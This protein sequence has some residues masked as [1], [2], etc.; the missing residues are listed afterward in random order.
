MINKKI[1]L[2]IPNICFLELTE[3]FPRDLKNE[4]ESSMVNE[5]SVFQSLRFS[6]ILFCNI[7]YN[8]YIN[9]D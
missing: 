2:N 8:Q 5:Q 1:S 4:F 3:E 9:A 6:S 7:Q